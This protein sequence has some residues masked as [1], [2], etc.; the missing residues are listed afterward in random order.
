MNKVW[1]TSDL[2]LGHERIIGYNRPQYHNLHEMHYD[3]I[4]RWNALVK[5]K[6]TVWVLGDVVF[7][8]D[9]YLYLPLLEQLN[10]N[11]NLILGNHDN[12]PMDNY[13]KY[14]KKIESSN[15]IGKCVL[16]HIPVHPQQLESRFKA[17]IHGHLHDSCLND[18]RYINVNMDQCDMRP[19][20]WSS[21][22]SR[23][24]KF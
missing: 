15:K 14:F 9:S 17:N 23:I 4:Q 24:S 10:G 21:I 5:D 13:Q 6:D 2:H 20:S 11:K 3:I 8:R 19:V 16:T 12:Y 22:E 18:K 1:F 7:G